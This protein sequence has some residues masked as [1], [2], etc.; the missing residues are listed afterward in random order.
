MSADSGHWSN[1][2]VNILP[3]FHHFTVPWPQTWMCRSSKL[4]H[5]PIL[6]YNAGR[7]PTKLGLEDLLNKGPVHPHC[8][9][10]FIKSSSFPTHLIQCTTGGHQLTALPFSLLECPRHTLQ[11]WCYDCK[12]HHQSLAWRSSATYTCEVPHGWTWRWVVYD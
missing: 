9:L 6:A 10:R 3:A 5:F 2:L 7:V 1:L 4:P 12:V 8:I 11:I